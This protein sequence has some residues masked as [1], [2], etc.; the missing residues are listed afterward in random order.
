MPVRHI[1]RLG[2]IPVLLLVSA[3][4][5]GVPSSSPNGTLGGQQPS[6]SMAASDAPSGLDAA[7]AELDHALQRLE[8]IHPEPYHAVDRATF[9]AELEE[10]K[11]RLPELTPEEAAVS[12][13][14]T[15][16]LLSTERDGHQLALP[17]DDGADPILPIRVYEFADGVFVTD[18]MAPY[19]DLVGSRITALGETGI[20]EALALLEPLVPRDGPATVAAFRPLYLLHVAVLRGLG[21]AGAGPVAISLEGADGPL[22]ASLEPVPSAAFREWAGWLPF[23]G[24]PA[25]DGLRYTQPAEAN[26]T[27]ELLDE[28]TVYARYRQVQ[29]VDGAALRELVELAGEP[30]VRRVIVDLRQNPGGDNHTYPPVVSALLDE[31]VDQPGRLVLLTDRVTF[32]AAANFATVVEQ[33]TT[34]TFA[35]EPM[36]GG[37][38]FWDDVDWITMPEFVLPMRVAIST[39]YWQKS[40]A[41]DA[42]LTIEPDMAQP[43]LSTDYFSGSDPLLAAVMGSHEP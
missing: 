31:A 1:R 43:V 25:R 38:N 5:T 15:W 27:V 36:G 11:R 39:R 3:C 13:M 12:L 42:R 30:S 21:L 18:A 20:D 10:L 19:Q 23:T 7:R 14:R 34:A 33:S 32:S 40:T 8:A 24:L 16:A 22:Q 9:V 2:F 41:D 4:A 17:L 37:L 26:L 29:R 28:N 6:A 35:G